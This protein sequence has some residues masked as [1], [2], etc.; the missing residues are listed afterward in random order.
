MGHF[1]IL[2]NFWSTFPGSQSI[3]DL[4]PRVMRHNIPSCM[5]RV[6]VNEA[7]Y[8]YMILHVP[9]TPSTWPWYCESIQRS[10][11]A[12]DWC[13][14]MLLEWKGKPLEVNGTNI[15]IRVMQSSGRLCLTLSDIQWIAFIACKKLTPTLRFCYHQGAWRQKIK[16]HFPWIKGILV[17]K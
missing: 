11:P 14:R 16:T 8:S 9:D 2:L 4:W 5:T 10:D 3:F 1:T 13:K 17:I 6:K 7:W 12:L 15:T